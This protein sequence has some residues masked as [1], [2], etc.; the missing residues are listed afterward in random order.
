MSDSPGSG[1]SSRSSLW[2]QHRHLLS[3]TMLSLS[4]G[5]GGVDTQPAAS[6][7][8]QRQ[9]MAAR[10]GFYW[11]CCQGVVSRFWKEISVLPRVQEPQSSRVVTVTWFIVSW[12]EN[13][14]FLL[15]WAYST[16]EFPEHILRSRGT[17]WDRE[18]SHFLA[19]AT[20][21]VHN[22]QSQNSHGDRKAS[23]RPWTDSLFCFSSF[24]YV[25]ELSLR[26]RKGAELEKLQ[27]LGWGTMI[28]LSF[29]CLSTSSI[30][31]FSQIKGKHLPLPPQIV[32]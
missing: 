3:F 7:Q 10:S 21:P 9:Q 27:H 19:R 8:L 16:A 5:G 2:F 30:L 14:K 31:H 25:V 1:T 22:K 12:S 23:L 15:E 29:T 24:I 20:P 13:P 17:C 32:N 4:V 28:T 6:A 18:L 11:F 26:R